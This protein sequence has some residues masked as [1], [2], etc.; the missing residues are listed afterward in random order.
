M[1]Y[2]KTTDHRMS[3]MAARGKERSWNGYGESDS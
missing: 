1:T 3:G 2:V